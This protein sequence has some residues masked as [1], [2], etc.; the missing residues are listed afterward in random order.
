M[1]A[2]LVST[3]DPLIADSCAACGGPLFGRYYVLMDRAERY[4][5]T[6]IATRPRC[7]SCGAPLELSHWQLH[8]GR[9]QCCRCHITAVYDGQLAQRIYHQTVESVA[10][11]F[12][13]RLRVGVEF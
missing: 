12:G 10:V 13:L 1:V 4:C 6:C 3:P 7:S 11:Q 9:L 5:Q 2:H 8:D